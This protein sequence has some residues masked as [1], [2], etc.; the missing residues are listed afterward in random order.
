MKSPLFHNDMAYGERKSLAKGVAP[1][2]PV[3]QGVGATF[4]VFFE[5]LVAESCRWQG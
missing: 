1:Y 4:A 3:E 5:L 2:S